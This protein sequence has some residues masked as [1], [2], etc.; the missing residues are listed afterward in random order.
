MDNERSQSSS[1]L[2]SYL[3]IRR[4]YSFLAARPYSI[5]M[6]GA[7][8]C[9]LA[10]KFFH[11]WRNDLVN[12]YG[13]WIL[14][15]ISVLLGIEVILTL[16]CFGWPRKLV[17]RIT[18]VFA[19][20][21]CTWSVMNAGWLIRTGRQILPSVLLS[22]IRDP[23]IALGMVGVNLIKMPKAAVILLGPSAVALT[24]F[25]YV[26]AKP[27]LPAYSHKRFI[28]RTIIC[29]VIILTAV[30][31]RD[32][33]VRQSSSQTI[34]EEMRYNCHLRAITSLFFSGT[35][36]L[37]KAD[38]ENAKRRIPAFDQ[39]QIDM[40]PRSQ[41]IN[42][43]VVIVV[44]E[45]V[46]YRYTSLAEPQS[47]LTPY[48]ASLAGQG[49]EFINARSTLTHT[50]KVLF[51]LLTGRFPSA[52]QDIAE[53]V[54]A[55]KPYAGIATILKKNLNFR[56]AFFQSAK[57]SFEARPGLVYN[58]GFDKFWTRD[59]LND[60]NA[61]IGYLAC[62]EFSMLQPISEWIKSEQR[63]FFLTVLCSVTHDPYE[64]PEWFAEP[65][66]EPVERYRQVISYTDK[67]IAALDAELG[68]LNLVDNTIF[69]VVADHGEAFG[70]HGLLGHERI[71][72]DEALRIPWIMRAP[73]LVKP[74]SKVT[75]PVSSID[76]VPTLL[77]LFGFD[78]NSVG[79]D[80]TDA[81]GHIPDDRPVYFSG[82]MQQGPAGFVEGN[83]KYVY[84][85]MDKKVSVYGLSSDPFELVRI[86]LA[87][88]KAQEIADDIIAWRKNSIF[89]LDRK[90]TGKKVL[91]D[92][93]LCR[94]T[95]RVS[96]VKY[97]RRERK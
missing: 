90:R 22:L 36:Q 29:I 81:L 64:V 14:A 95:N 89:R 10:V 8:F 65:A 61:F 31:L 4:L 71:A 69:C 40:S 17:V 38:F 46:Q 41:R 45:G 92:S 1:S 83:R 96:S 39:V 34:S 16:V 66:K 54:P 12:E 24:F 51:A 72:F 35:G 77:T 30:S 97:R 62:D 23:L 32:V 5:I 28:K 47:N 60:P 55:A 52:S 63:P 18:T 57:G 11:S 48:L 76:L 56:T 2:A 74:K 91:F 93:W 42:H 87:E 68:K 3:S 37:A 82:W 80:G 13:G 25:F 86:E 15:D 9:T 94:W 78:T 59:D 53:T 33:V 6:F 85:P 88:Q 50:T 27:R 26:L 73:S 58:L 49:A 79:F 20:I 67:F 43:N 84:N 70:E 7:L 75:E 44:L 21:V 19:A